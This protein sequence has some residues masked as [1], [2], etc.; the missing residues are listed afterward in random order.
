MHM[1]HPLRAAGLGRTQQAVGP[2][3]A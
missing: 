2:R 1:E 3:T